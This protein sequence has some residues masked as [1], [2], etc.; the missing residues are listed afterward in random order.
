MS[1]GSR[2]KVLEQEVIKKVR[3]APGLALSDF[4]IFRLEYWSRGGMFAWVAV[5]RGRFSDRE[6]SHARPTL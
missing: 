2:E 6:G 4:H 3:R 5:P 1:A